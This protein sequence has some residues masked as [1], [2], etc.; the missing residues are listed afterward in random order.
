MVSDIRLFSDHK[1]A[2]IVIVCNNS[3]E[4]AYLLDWCITKGKEVSDWMFENK[5]FPICYCCHDEIVG[6]TR[7]MDRAIGYK[8]FIVFYN[9][10][11][12]SV[13]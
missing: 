4:Q 3:S 9:Q 7:S 6:F 2:R 8:E 11:M 10:L 12:D 5:E 13:N 1:S